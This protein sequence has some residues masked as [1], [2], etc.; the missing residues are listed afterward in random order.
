VSSCVCIMSLKTERCLRGF[1]IIWWS[2]SRHVRVCRSVVVFDMHS[3]LVPAVDV[4]NLT[5]NSWLSKLKFIL[6][7]VILC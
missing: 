3:V 4:D 2:I 7:V 5:F 1:V 6:Y